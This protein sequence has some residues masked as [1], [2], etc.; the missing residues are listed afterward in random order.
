VNEVNGTPRSSAYADIAVDQRGFASKKDA[1]C[2]NKTGPQTNGV[3]P[4]EL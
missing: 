2:E 1:A 4:Y 3:K